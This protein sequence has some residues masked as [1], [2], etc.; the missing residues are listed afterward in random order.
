MAETRKSEAMIWVGGGV[1][2]LMLGALA[3][4]LA[5]RSARRR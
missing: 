3:L 5:A 4:L 2:Y 1:A